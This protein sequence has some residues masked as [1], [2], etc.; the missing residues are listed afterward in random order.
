MHLELNRL[1][2]AYCVTRIIDPHKVRDLVVHF[3][4][5]NFHSEMVLSL[6][7]SVIIFSPLA[8]TIMV[9]GPLAC[10]NHGH[11]RLNQII[12]WIMGPQMAHAHE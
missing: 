11:M 9:L 8:R 1:L 3:E 5:D 6:N 12:E 10:T 7:K 4:G 2:E